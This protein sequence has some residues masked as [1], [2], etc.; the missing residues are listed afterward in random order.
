MLTNYIENKNLGKISGMM[1]KK[2]KI[3]DARVAGEWI[4]SINNTKL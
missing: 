3:F 1:H 4:A 2:K